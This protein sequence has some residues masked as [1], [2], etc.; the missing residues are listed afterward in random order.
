MLPAPVLFYKFGAQIRDSC[1]YTKLAE[2]ALQGMM[3]ASQPEK[4]K[5]EV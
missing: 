1:K 2:E 3:Q 5:A 4:K